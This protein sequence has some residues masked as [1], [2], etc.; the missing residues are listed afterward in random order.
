V[1]AVA[2]FTRFAENMV[3]VSGL[4][5]TLEVFG[6]EGISE[7]FWWCRTGELPVKLEGDDAQQTGDFVVYD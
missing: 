6:F 1:A 7:P 2:F 3:G 5:G 4:R